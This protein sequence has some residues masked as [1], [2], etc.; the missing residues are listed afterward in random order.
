M[1]LHDSSTE[2]LTQ[3]IL[4]YAVDRVRLDP[5]PLDSPRTPAELSAMAGRT[6]TPR[7]L[8]GLEALRVFGDV[9]AP[10][11]ISVDHPRFLSLS[12][13]HI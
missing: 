6:V 10:A 9:L 11:C 12:L 13:I 1:H 2:V 7:G 3:A 5:P 8:G 4:R